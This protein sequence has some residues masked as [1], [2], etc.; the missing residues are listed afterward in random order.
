MISKNTAMAD[1]VEAYRNY[2]N[3]PKSDIRL[4]CIEATSHLKTRFK[5]IE[6]EV[7]CG[8][9]PAVRRN[10]LKPRTDVY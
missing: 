8:T 7:F 2:T 4:L 1:F 3:L 9:P 6:T 10:S 5:F